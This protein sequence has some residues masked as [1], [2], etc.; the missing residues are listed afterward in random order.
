MNVYLTDLQKQWLEDQRFTFV[1]RNAK[2]E[3]DVHLEATTWV[4]KLEE[5]LTLAIQALCSP[6]NKANVKV[7]N[8]IGAYRDQRSCVKLAIHWSHQ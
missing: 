6:L 4:I 3:K 1:E 2:V 8:L 7:P 5:H